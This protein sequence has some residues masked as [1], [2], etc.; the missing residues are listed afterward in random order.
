MATIDSMAKTFR[1]GQIMGIRIP[2]VFSDTDAIVCDGCGRAIEITPFRVSIMDAIAGESPPSWAST[3][4]INPGPHQFHADPACFW[5]WAGQR[6]YLACRLA[7]VR[8]LMRPI[9]LP[10]A[11]MRWGLCDGEHREAHEFLPD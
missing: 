4:T 6:G 5:A 7:M 8:E 10:G 11:T 3:V 1:G 2:T 9:P